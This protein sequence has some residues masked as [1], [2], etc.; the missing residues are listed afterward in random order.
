[1]TVISIFKG[2]LKK[3]QKYK[4]W[5]FDCLGFTLSSDLECRPICSRTW[6][7]TN[8]QDVDVDRVYDRRP[9]PLYPHY[10]TTLQYTDL[11]KLL[12]QHFTPT[13]KVFFQFDERDR[14]M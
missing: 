3:T 9:K 12:I 6:E 14:L 8:L 10:V 4:I 13:Y 11:L 1:V 2:F 7:I 5:I